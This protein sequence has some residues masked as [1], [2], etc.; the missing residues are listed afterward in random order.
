MVGCWLLVSPN[1]FGQA[2]FGEACTLTSQSIGWSYLDKSS[3]AGSD[4]EHVGNERHSQ[5]GC[6]GLRPNRT[7]WNS[8]TISD[9]SRTTS[10][11][12]DDL[13][14]VVPPCRDTHR[15]FACSWFIHSLQRGDRDDYCSYWLVVGYTFDVLL[16]P[17]RSLNP[18]RCNAGRSRFMSNCMSGDFWLEGCRL[19][20]DLQSGS[21]KSP[22]RFWPGTGSGMLVRFGSVWGGDVN[23]MSV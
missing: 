3:A 4:V 11:M 23:C 14:Q 10:D 22:R 5:S 7:Q 13:P 8:V 18:A 20:D 19:G 2:R 9:M 6:A 21:I 1:V 16:P 15:I 12:F 17:N